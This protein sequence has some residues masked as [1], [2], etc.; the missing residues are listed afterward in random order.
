MSNA[1]DTL[2]STFQNKTP[3]ILTAGQQTREMLLLEPWLANPAP[4]SIAT[5]WV[6]WAA[7]P[8]PGDCCPNGCRDT[9]GSW[10]W[11]RPCSASTRGCPASTSPP[12]HACCT[13][14]TIQPRRGALG[15]DLPAAVGIAVAE[16]DFESG[17]PVV[18]NNGEYGILK[19][20][21]EFQKSPGVPG[22][23]LPGLKPHLIAQGYGAPGIVATT[24]AEVRA[25]L[26]GAWER[27]GPTLIEVP[28]NPTIPPLV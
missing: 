6:K 16:R 28:I 9:T 13:S 15:G 12:A 22:L 14:P 24:A 23:D 10:W 18:P 17:R 25:A 11:E 20:F 8:S 5:T 1:L 27:S 4:Q 3:L 2:D 26:D 21:A 7:C 19:S